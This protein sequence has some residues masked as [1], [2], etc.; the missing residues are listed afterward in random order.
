[1]Y[2]PITLRAKTNTAVFSLPSL[3]FQTVLELFFI[4][5]T[6]FHLQAECVWWVVENVE[7]NCCGLISC[8]CIRTD[9]VTPWE[10]KFLLKMSWILSGSETKISENCKIYETVWSTK[11]VVCNNSECNVLRVGVWSKA[12][13]CGLLM[14]GNA[15]YILLG[16]WMS[17]CFECCMLSDRGFCDGPFT[18]PEES[19]WVC[20]CVC[21][22]VWSWNLDK[23]EV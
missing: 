14:A 19:Y 15:G 16:S 7:A 20:V 11:H 8:L 21:V 1:M 5:W 9:W 17:V 4:Y 12:W 22:W 13:I 2:L 10:P 23:E 6:V 3:V 18:H